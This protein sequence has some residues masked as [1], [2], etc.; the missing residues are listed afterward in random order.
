MKFGLYVILDGSFVRGGPHRGTSYEDLARAVL[1]GGARVV[2][3]RDK[4][5]PTRDLINV[6]RRLKEIVHAQGGIFIV[7]DRVDVAM[8]VD[9]DGVHLGQEDMPVE[10]ARPLLG[11][12]KIIGVSARTVEAA[13]RAEKSGATYIGTGAIRSTSSKQDATVIGINGLR[14]I[15]RATEIPVV[16]IGGITTEMVEPVIEAGASGIAVISAVLGA[17]DITGATMELYARVDAALAARDRERM[18]REYPQ[19]PR[20]AASVLVFDGTGRVLLARRGCDPNYG[21]WSLP[22]GLVELGERVEECAAREVY[23]ECGIEVELRGIVDVVDAIIRDTTGRVRF[24]YVIVVFRGMRRRGDLRPSLEL[25]E[26]AW[27]PLNEAQGL[28]LTD[29]T[30]DV[31]QRYVGSTPDGALTRGD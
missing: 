28:D 10:V 22:G 9:A 5:M 17:P 25:L 24:D 19:G 2:Q 11:Y 7:N 26:A 23:E 31:L 1:L 15:C 14:E 20:V 8:A 21:K 4:E 30:R 29:T 18:R 27:V 16:A 12:G 3:L 13:I 6:A